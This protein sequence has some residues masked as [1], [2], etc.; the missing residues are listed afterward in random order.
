[1]R[2]PEQKAA[3]EQLKNNRNQWRR[4]S[5]GRTEFA[6]QKILVGVLVMGRALADPGVAEWLHLVIEQ[7]TKR[8]TDA[9]TLAPVLAQLKEV[10]TS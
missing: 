3:A 9:A 2:T 5:L 10:A 1:M 6:R 8:D 7:D 4:E